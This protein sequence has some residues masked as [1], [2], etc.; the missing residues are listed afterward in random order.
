MT[1]DIISDSG[2]QDSLS[3][4]IDGGTEPPY[5]ILQEQLDEEGTLSFSY[6]YGSKTGTFTLTKEQAE[7]LIKVLTDLYNKVVPS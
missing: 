1:V 5:E 6:E 4:V 2:K 3:V 7:Q